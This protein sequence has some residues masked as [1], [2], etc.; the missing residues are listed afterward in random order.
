MS[1]VL[2][3]DRHLGTQ[4]PL[5]SHK[6]GILYRLHF[7]LLFSCLIGAAAGIYSDHVNVDREKRGSLSVQIPF[8]SLLNFTGNMYYQ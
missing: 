7:C 3:R 1:Y 8:R 4:E 2:P 6:L 5:N